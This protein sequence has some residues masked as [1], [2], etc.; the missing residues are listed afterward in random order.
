M[1][2]A[3]IVSNIVATKRYLNSDLFLNSGNLNIYRTVELPIKAVIVIIS[4][5]DKTIV[6]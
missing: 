1:Y 2:K 6:G 3:F 4:E 5:K